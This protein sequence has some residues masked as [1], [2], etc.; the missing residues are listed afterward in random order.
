MWTLWRKDYYCSTTLINDTL[1]IPNQSPNRRSGTQNIQRK[2]F[3]FFW[4]WWL[5]DVATLVWSSYDKHNARTSR[6]WLQGALRIQNHS[7]VYLPSGQKLLHN[8]CEVRKQTSKLR[9]SFSEKYFKYYWDQNNIQRVYYNEGLCIYRLWMVE[10]AITKQLPNT[11]GLT[12]KTET[13]QML[14]HLVRFSDF[15]NLL[16]GLP[17]AWSTGFLVDY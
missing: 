5:M 3:L 16:T 15:C 6:P 1:T 11:R 8:L 12:N 9:K 17:L 2:D 14:Q 10:L 4:W 13:K 7:V